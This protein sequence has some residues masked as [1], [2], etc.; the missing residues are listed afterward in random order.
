MITIALA[1]YNGEKYI[2]EQMASLLNQDIQEVLYIVAADDGSSDDTFEILQEYAR[3]YPEKI[4]AY[5]NEVPTGS[6]KSNFFSLLKNI[7]DDY[8]MLCDQD[9]VW[10]PEKVQ[11]TYKKMKELEAQFGSD[12]PLLVF[13]D[14]AVVDENLKV[15]SISMADYQKTAPHHNGLNH[16]LVQNNIIGCTVMINRALLKHMDF[17][18][19]VC[20]MHDWWLGLLASAFGHIGFVDKPL[21]GYRQHGN[22]Q[23]G[24]RAANDPS[25]Y[26][27]RLS[28]GEEVRRNYDIMFGQA[29]IFLEQYRNNL[30]K[31]QVRLLEG[32]L[33]IR[34]SSRVVKIYKIFKYRLFKSTWFWTLGQCLSI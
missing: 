12:S 25:Q 7:D 2:G 34:N 32:F 21:M 8:V 11:L 29:E 4:T 20:M 14:V 6:A 9:D 30:S 17:E 1:A 10:L 31:E 5:R 15:I 13:T 24:T 27:E 26:V 23:M 33:S 18:P 19:Q 16:Y 28:K 22:N 3:R